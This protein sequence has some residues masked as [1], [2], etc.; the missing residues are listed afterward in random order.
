[1]YF[2]WLTLV[3]HFYSKA[4]VYVFPTFQIDPIFRVVHAVYAV[5]VIQFSR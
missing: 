4:I 3:V 2:K 5:Q 1:M